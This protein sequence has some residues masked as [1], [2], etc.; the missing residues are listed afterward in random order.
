[1]RL[2]DWLKSIFECIKSADVLGFLGDVAS[3]TLGEIFGD[4][5]EKAAGWIKHKCEQNT[6]FSK[7]VNEINEQ[8]DAEQERQ[9]K[10]LLAKMQ[11]EKKGKRAKS[12]LSPD[13]L[14]A[15]KKKD[16]DCVKR[17]FNDCV[18][19]VGDESAINAALC[20]AFPTSFNNAE[21][22]IK[23]L[24]V[25]SIW[26][27]K[28]SFIEEKLK[29]TESGYAASWLANY[30]N[31]KF[32]GIEEIS[33]RL[34]EFFSQMLLQANGEASLASVK[35]SENKNQWLLRECPV[36]GYSRERLIFGKYG[37]VVC[38]A[39]GNRYA[40][41]NDIDREFTLKF[42]TSVERKLDKIE[43]NTVKNIEITE[44]NS[45]KID[46]GKYNE[47]LAFCLDH[48]NDLE[49]LETYLK[50]AKLNEDTKKLVNEY[51]AN[52]KDSK[53]SREELDNSNGPDKQ[54]KLSVFDAIKAIDLNLLSDSNENGEGLRLD[55]SQARYDTIKKW[56]DD[57]VEIEKLVIKSDDSDK[58]KEVYFGLV[59]INENLVNL[60][61][62]F[63][64]KL[65]S[66][67]KLAP[68]DV[69]AFN[70]KLNENLQE[71]SDIYKE[72]PFKRQ[73]PCEFFFEYRIIPSVKNA[74]K[75]GKTQYSDPQLFVECDDDGV[76]KLF[77]VIPDWN[78]GEERFVR[79]EISDDKKDETNWDEIWR[80]QAEKT[81]NNK[82]FNKL[83]IIFKPGKISE[84]ICY[85]DIFGEHSDFKTK[86][87]PNEKN[88]TWDYIKYW[89]EERRCDIMDSTEPKFD[90]NG[91]GTIRLS[92]NKDEK[93]DFIEYAFFINFAFRKRIV[94][95]ITAI[96]D[97][98]AEKGEAAADNNT[99]EN[100][101]FK[102]KIN[103]LKRPSVN[104]K[105]SVKLMHRSK[106]EI[107]VYDLPEKDKL[108]IVGPIERSD[109]NGYYL[110]F[111]DSKDERYYLLEQ[112]A[113]NHGVKASKQSNF[114]KAFVDE[115]VCPFC[116]N[117]IWWQGSDETDSY[118]FGG[119]ISCQGE[120][121]NN[122]IKDNVGERWQC[123]YCG[124]DIK[125]SK[126]GFASSRDSSVK[127]N[128]ILPEDFLQSDSF[129][130]AVVGE[131]RS[132]KSFMLSRLFPFEPKR[133]HVAVDLSPIRAYFRQSGGIT[134]ETLLA[135]DEE[136]DFLALD[137]WRS[138]IHAKLDWNARTGHSPDAT[139]KVADQ[140]QSEYEILERNPIVLSFNKRVS[141]FK[142]PRKQYLFVYDMPGESFAP[143]NNTA[144]LKRLPLID[145]PERLGCIFL[146][147]GDKEDKD[148]AKKQHET[149]RGLIERLHN[150]NDP[151][152]YAQIPLAIVFTKF[153]IYEKYFDSNSHCLRGDTHDMAYFD[154]RG[155]L[156]YSGTALQ[157]NID[158]A[159]DEIENF[160]KSQFKG[161]YSIF[162][163]LSDKKNREL[164]T[165]I[166]YFGVSTVGF[167]GAIKKINSETSLVQFGTATKRLELPFIW[168]LN[169]YGI[170][171]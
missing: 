94:Y 70:D 116:H 83:Q 137:K 100:K 85:D 156:R 69:K 140:S 108:L 30:I 12:E 26:Q 107:G 55:Q 45:V 101:S 130:L 99:E 161:K 35:L 2:G 144:Q 95:Q 124:K 73:K 34:Q 142:N 170:I 15:I 119:G 63:K 163:L 159:S 75:L 106:G 110:T 48:R 109:I 59:K 123:I 31:E 68:K 103:V 81:G 61:N 74:A 21:E 122:T 13:T 112:M 93:N 56:L 138:P 96:K 47:V 24:V 7:F 43:Q 36:C 134:G 8:A 129:R 153:D 115:I 147:N 133:E 66:Q 158:L 162:N 126:D 171:D 78:C 33:K 89:Q 111:A 58:I 102:I 4:A 128:R 168:M 77:A 98:P 37:E 125:D 72:L 51:I 14:E 87:D 148:L 84:N 42:Q 71:L 11:A 67:K 90:F 152:L 46:E 157:N 23:N 49:A 32:E 10:I 18:D 139:K 117:R 57:K 44:E 28:I 9:L 113:S 141:W 91:C 97:A 22:G 146:F 40:S 131:T 167:E 19:E 132:G 27:I 114:R 154:G 65:D 50:T 25:N 166:K 155:N 17:L 64:P 160:L 143:R 136:K 135:V 86:I 29:G 165:E 6:E 60:I 145:Y 52:C 62:E 118:D 104:G 92:N 150:F 82:R 79:L 53:T 76:H 105:I 151:E 3:N 121:L 164:F 88:I 38:A 41:E 39:C 120:K 127:Y 16:A 169:Q 20:K 5:T 54:L 80:S 149:L 1:M